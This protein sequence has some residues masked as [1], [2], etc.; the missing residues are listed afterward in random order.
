LSRHVGKGE[1][2]RCPL[3]NRNTVDFTR[4]FAR[5]IKRYCARDISFVELTASVQG[6]VNHVRYADTWGLREHVFTTHPIG[7]PGAEGRRVGGTE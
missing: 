6:W 1:F 3:K 5:N 2:K 4:R 7:R